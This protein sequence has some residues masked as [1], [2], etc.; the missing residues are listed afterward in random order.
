MYDAVSFKEI[1]DVLDIENPDM[2]EGINDSVS[3]SRTVPAKLPDGAPARNDFRFDPDAQPVSVF[4]EP[5]NPEVLQRLSRRNS[6][7]K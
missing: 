5:A 6:V 2:N 1:P 3:D 7:C 4:L